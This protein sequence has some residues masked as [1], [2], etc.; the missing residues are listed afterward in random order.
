[1]RKWRK[2]IV[3]AGVSVVALFLVA[4]VVMLRVMAPKLRAMA[5]REVQDHLQ[6]H[7]K[8]SVHFDDFE[9]TFYPRIHVVV[10]GLILRHKA[11]TDIPPLI[12]VQRVSFYTTLT[13]LLR[14]RPE[15]GTVEL[16]GLQIHTPPRT[17]GGPPMIHGTDQNLAEKYPILIHEIIADHAL[18]VLLRKDSDKPPNQFEIHHLVMND[19]GFDRPAAFHALLTNPKP[20]GYIHCDGEF[21]PWRADEPSETPVSASYTFFNADLGTIKGLR[22]ILSSTGK[23]GGPLD[24]LNVEGTTDTPGFGL[25][26]SGHPMALHTDFTA[27]VDGTNGDTVLT[28]VTAK[29]LQT[30]LVT[31]GEVVDVYPK[32]KGRT[33]ALDAVSSDARIEDLLALAMKSDR[34]MMT[35]SA[36][37]KTKILIPERDEDMVDRLQLDG[38]FGLGN[39]HFTSSTVQGKVDSLSRR[40]QGRPKDQDISDAMSDLSGSFKMN[41][42]TINFS[43]LSFGVE[44]ASVVLG[45]SY[46]FDSGQLDF[47]GK[48]RLEA[49]LSQTMTGWKSVVLKPFNHFFEGKDGGTEIPIKI[50]GTRDHPAFGADFH[51]KANTK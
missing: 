1:M 6:T 38:Q 41:D 22:G 17:P 9:V 37:L 34:P 36:D 28:K 4:Y 13:G 32:V 8:S 23:F 26:T 14:D 31:H 20:R 45:G 42:G 27:I 16:D 30:T 12:Q 48:L 19:F 15:I 18:L 24:Y 2:W 11:R 43:N 29:F 47:R 33:I 50:T 46:S 5:R 3:L 44:G 7:F 49:K 25:R 10:Y 35:G 21:G 39:V 40:G 51:D